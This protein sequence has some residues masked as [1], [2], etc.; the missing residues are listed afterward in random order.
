MSS[1]GRPPKEVRRAP[2]DRIV[3]NCTPEE[4]QAIVAAAKQAKLAVA[5]WARVTLLSAAQG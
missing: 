2:K 5:V 3:V 4:R 1:V